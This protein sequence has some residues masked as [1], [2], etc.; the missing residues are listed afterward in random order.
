GCLP[1]A[2]SSVLRAA[3]AVARPVLSPYVGEL[4]VPARALE[5]AARAA[6]LPARPGGGGGGAFLP[7][8][9][10]R[11]RLRRALGDVELLGA[12]EVDLHRSR[13][14]GAEAVRD[15]AARLPGLPSLCRGMRRAPPVPAR[16]GRGARVEGSAGRSPRRP[17]GGGRRPGRPVP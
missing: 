14:R 15:A 8:A 10:G 3:V 7:D 1:R 16:M 13:L 6:Q 4:R 5:P 9:R 2:R 11:A 17:G 12:L